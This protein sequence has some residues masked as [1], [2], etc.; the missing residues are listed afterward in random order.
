MNVWAVLLTAISQSP[1]NRL[2]VVVGD[3]NHKLPI[4]TTCVI[5]GL[6]ANINCPLP[7]NPHVI[8]VEPCEALPVVSEAPVVS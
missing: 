4:V 3:G 1:I 8:L 6:L 7:A 5:F 2:P